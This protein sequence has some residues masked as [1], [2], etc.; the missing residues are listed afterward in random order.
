[1]GAC[2]WRW[3]S[4][5]LV[6]R[7]FVPATARLRRSWPA[8]DD[9]HRN[10]QVNPDVSYEASDASATAV[11]VF[12]VTLFV[13]TAIIYVVVWWIFGYLAGRN[14]GREKRASR[15][16]TF[17]GLAGR[18]AVGRP[19]RRP[20]R[21]GGGQRPDAAGRLRLGR[22]QGGIGAD[23]GGAGGIASGRA[24]AGRGEGVEAMRDLYRNRLCAALAVA[25][26]LAGVRAAAALPNTP[27]VPAK[28]SDRGPAA[29]EAVG[30]GRGPL[31]AAAQPAGAAGAGVPRR[32]GA[33]GEA[34]RTTWGASR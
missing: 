9:T 19:D 18:P 15:P 33:R 16:S 26:V 31:R 3:C 34:R 14:T 11:I 24:A 6:A 29:V 25:C 20:A 21:A 22:P 7:R 8:M 2:G 27:Y 17:Q 5:S 10:E 32:N 30:S 28:R 1:M 13:C 12:G 4:G 23:S